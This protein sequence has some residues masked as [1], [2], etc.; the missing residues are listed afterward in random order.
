[1]QRKITSRILTGMAIRAAREKQGLSRR[2]LAGR[3][4]MDYTYLWKI[5]HGIKP[6]S[7]DKLDAIIDALGISHYDF[8]EL[9]PAVIYP[10]LLNSF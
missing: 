5:E 4:E 9:I 8:F 6:V 1:M 2:E 7:Q 10:Q 3:L